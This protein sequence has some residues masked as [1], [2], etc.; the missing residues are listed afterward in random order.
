MLD[1]M[2][3]SVNLRLSLTIYSRFEMTKFGLFVILVEIA[4]LAFYAKEK[5][6]GGVFWCLFWIWGVIYYE[7]FYY[8]S[9]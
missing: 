7:K 2:N 3:M 8:K 4:G 1:I 6:L 9:K 5:M